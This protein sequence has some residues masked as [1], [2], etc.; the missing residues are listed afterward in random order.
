MTQGLAGG[1][2]ETGR[3][4]EDSFLFFFSI[5]MVTA[6]LA[7]MEEFPLAFKKKTAKREILHSTLKKEGKKKKRR[8]I[9]FD[10]QIMNDSLPAVEA[11]IKDRDKIHSSSCYKFTSQE[12]GGRHN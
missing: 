4:R 11:Q 10:Q 12:V 2:K 8:E 1:Q 5:R 6:E 9:C 3:E 7:A